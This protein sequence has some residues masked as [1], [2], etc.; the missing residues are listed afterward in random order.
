MAVHIQR[1]TNVSHFIS[2]YN[3]QCMKCIVDIFH[4][5]R[6]LD[7][8][9]NKFPGNIPIE[10]PHLIHCHFIV[11]P[12]KGQRRIQ[13]IMDGC[14]FSEELWIGYHRKISISLLPGN[15]FYD[16]SDLP[17]RSRKHSAANRYNMKIIL[18][19]QRH[20]D[21]SGHFINIFQIQMSFFTAWRPYCD[22][23]NLRIIYGICGVHRGLQPALCMGIFHQ[24][25]N[26]FLDDG[27]TSL[28]DQLHLMRRHIHTND[29]MS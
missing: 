7:I 25:I 20:T 5:L 12:H 9:G 8:C 4:H 22:K 16:L 29:M 28:I 24:F 3:L 27:R 2:K 10:S 21:L 1:L 14:P 15:F 6:H 23:R 11:R 19:L 13:V 18:I 17:V 26:I